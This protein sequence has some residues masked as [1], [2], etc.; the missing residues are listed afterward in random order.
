VIFFKRENQAA[1]SVM[2]GKKNCDPDAVDSNGNCM[3]KGRVKAPL[4]SSQQPNAAPLLSPSS[5]FLIR[6]ESA[7]PVMDAFARLEQLGEHKTASFQAPAVRH[8]ADRYVVTVKLENP[9]LKGFDPFTVTTGEPLLLTTLK[10]RHGLVKPVEVEFS[11]VGV[12]SAVHLFFPRSVEG[13][14]LF[15]GRRDWA[16]FQLVGQGFAAR[17]RFVLDFESSDFPNNN[18]GDSQ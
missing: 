3:Q 7:T 14:P 10:S 16:E 11:G 6:W 17:C 9:G 2:L 15:S 18:K 1:Y 5:S 8:P 13:V 12:S 4:D